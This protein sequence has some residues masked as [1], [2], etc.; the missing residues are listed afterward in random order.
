MRKLLIFICSAMMSSVLL[1]ACA[2]VEHNYTPTTKIINFPA[3]NTQTTVHIGEAMIDQGKRVTVEVLEV[4]P[5]VDELCY[6]IPA[7]T[8]RKQGT[9]KEKTFYSTKGTN[10]KVQRKGV[11]DPVEGMYTSDEKD[12][13]ICIFNSYGLSACYDANFSIINQAIPVAGK[14]QQMLYFS[15]KSK[16]E[17][18]L[19]YAEKMGTQTSHTHNISYNLEES[20]I[21]NYR[22]AKIKIIDSTHDSITYEVLKKF[23]TD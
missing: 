16:D 14:M 8:Y 11:C 13:K 22:G 6:Y 15:G 19:M 7:G 4:D 23:N 17:V 21:I 9:E 20:N 10:G 12:G 5:S 2:K 3:N 1:S 18:R